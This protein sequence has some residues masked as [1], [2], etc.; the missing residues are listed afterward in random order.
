MSG[1]L[2]LGIAAA[3]IGWAFFTRKDGNAAKEVAKSPPFANPNP[4]DSNT[5]ADTPSA[6]DGGIAAIKQALDEES[7]TTGVETPPII[8]SDDGQVL[9]VKYG[10]IEAKA[11][12]VD[13]TKSTGG[14][15]PS[16]Q[17]TRIHDN[18]HPDSPPS[19]IRG[20]T[21]D[22]LLAAKYGVCG[23]N[24]LTRSQIA[25]AYGEASVWANEVI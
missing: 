19:V 11:L 1:P 17:M 3:G 14:A 16:T 9:S 25:N 2:L 20:D 22:I 18:D 23:A 12:V 24:G 15:D 10:T 5:L 6:S 4:A 13:N 8:G 21:E 7:K